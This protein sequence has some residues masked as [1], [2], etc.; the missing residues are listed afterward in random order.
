MKDKTEFCVECG[1]YNIEYVTGPEVVKVRGDEITVNASYWVCKDCNVE[2]ENLCDGN[3]YLAEAYK[4]YRKKHNMLQPEEIKALRLK[5]DLTQGELAQILGWGLATLSRYE[6]GSLQ[7]FAHDKILKLLKK[8]PII[9]LQ[10]LS[11]DVINILGK[12]KYE[13]VKNLCE[14]M[15]RIKYKCNDC[16]QSILDSINSEVYAI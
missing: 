7:D 1:S 6:K 10:L 12:T 14:N 11:N 16:Y 4:I 9:L 13:K 5:Y 15:I 8:E 2:F 3:D